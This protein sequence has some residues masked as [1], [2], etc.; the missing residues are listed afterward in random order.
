MTSRPIWAVEAR[1]KD[2]SQPPLIVEIAAHSPTEALAAAVAELVAGPVPVRLDATWPDCVTV[3]AHPSSTPSGDRYSVTCRCGA[4]WG[5]QDRRLTLNLLRDTIPN[6]HGPG[7]CED[8]WPEN[9][10]PT[11][12]PVNTTGAEIRQRREAAGMSQAQLAEAV[13]VSPATI[14]I[15]ER[16]LGGVSPQ[17]VGRIR[18]A[19]D[20]AG[21]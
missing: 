5:T 11:P 10:T 9:C 15:S 14:S 17:T 2:G 18:T 4:S 19:L 1:C 6:H 7:R 16:V 13:G 20:E 3:I 8:R 21:A 12:E